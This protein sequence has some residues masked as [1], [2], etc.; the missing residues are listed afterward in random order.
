MKMMWDWVPNQRLGPIEIGISVET[1]VG[2]L[3]AQLLAEIDD[4]T[5]WDSYYIPH[6]DVYI[7]AEDGEVVSISAHK[8]FYYGIKNVLGM[9]IEQLEALL[10]CKADE[11][12]NSVEY[13]DGD[14]Q[15]P[16]D[17]SELGLVAWV[18]QDV[19][20]NVVCT[21]YEGLD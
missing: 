18:S 13:E 1:Y 21:T 11:I 5:G 9:T 16:Y 20:V 6:H 12:G 17:Y 8:S 2:Q 4:S 10:G 3:G 7:N 15:T 19:I 14:I